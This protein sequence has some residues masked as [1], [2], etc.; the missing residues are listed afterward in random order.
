MATGTVHRHIV[1]TWSFPVGRLFGIAIRVHATF[2]LVLLLVA[3]A[4]TLGWLVLIFACVV[5][6]ELAHSILA[7]RNGA[8]V[9][10]ILLFPLG[11]VSKIRNLGDDPRVEAW[12][13]AVGPLA[14]M[15]LAGVAALAA[16]VAGVELLP[17]DLYGGA[18]L[19][20]LAWFNLLLGAFNLLPAFPMDGGRLFRALLTL[21]LGPDRATRVAAVVA[22]GL[23]GGMFVAGLYMSVWLVFI[24][25][26]V[27]L[28]AT[29]EE[30]SSALHARARGLHVGDV[31]LL[32]PTVLDASASLGDVRMVAR[33]SAQP[34]FPV[35]RFGVYAGLLD[36]DAIRELGP[37]TRAGDAADRDAP[38]LAPDDLLDPTAFEALEDSGREVL[39]VV[40]AGRVVGLLRE[41]DIVETLRRRQP[42][43]Q[44][45]P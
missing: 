13:A 10:E 5:V 1:H 18:I 16:T 36:A 42:L 29:S 40:D 32:E 30:A 8:E 12:V 34:V 3:T 14:S 20:R 27:Y 37:D 39:A 17:P 25:G 22:R 44:P 26:F 31:M 38:V 21:R 41:E 15:A 33:R 11:G 35:A 23:A 6:H 9:D 43:D 24:A 4:G 19:A 7:R 45:R 28:G 2:L